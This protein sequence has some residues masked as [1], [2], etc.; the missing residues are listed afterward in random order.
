[1]QLQLLASILIKKDQRMHLQLLASN[2][3]KKD[4][5]MYLQLLASNILRPSQSMSSTLRS[6]ISMSSNRA[7]WIESN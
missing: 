2:L 7:A 3:I 5:R 6:R 1:M 4:Q